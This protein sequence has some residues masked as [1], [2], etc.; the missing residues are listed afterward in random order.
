MVS[1][2][3]W[4]MWLSRTHRDTGERVRELDHRVGRDGDVHAGRPDDGLLSVASNIPD[5]VLALGG[6]RVDHPDVDP[7]ATVTV[8]LA[9]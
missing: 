1:Q 4:I 5:P 3:S 8:C 7:K 9:A 2:R 6:G